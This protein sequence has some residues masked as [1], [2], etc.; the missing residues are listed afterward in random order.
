MFFVC[1]YDGV[2]DMFDKGAVLSTACAV[3]LNWRIL[4]RTNQ[5]SPISGLQPVATILHCKGIEALRRY[6]NH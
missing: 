3:W 1:V 5:K 4:A 2:D 6:N